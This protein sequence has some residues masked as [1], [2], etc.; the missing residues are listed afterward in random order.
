MA[1]IS[2][3]IELIEL[4]SRGEEVRDAITDALS[5]MNGD[6]NY[7]FYEEITVTSATSDSTVYTGGYKFEK[8]VEGVDENTFVEPCLADLTAYTGR[9][10]AKSTNGKITLYF[11]RQPTNGTVVKVCYMNQAVAKGS[12]SSASVNSNN[13]LS[14]G[15]ASINNNV[16]GV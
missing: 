16:L 15:N 3:Y 12:D 11:D 13:I 5:A 8:A 1:N 7:I 6:I 4:A 9:Y 14:L 10:A 2:T